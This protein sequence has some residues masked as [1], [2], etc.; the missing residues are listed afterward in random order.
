M[1]HIRARV[2]LAV[3]AGALVTWLMLG[4]PSG[5]AGERIA[6]ISATLSSTDLSML[7]PAAA[8]YACSLVARAARLNL[9]GP[10][11]MSAGRALQMTAI[12]AGLGHILPL[13]LSD[14]A[15]VGLLRGYAS[16]PAGRGT[17]MVILSKL[18]DVSSLGL[19]IS[20]AFLFGAGTRVTLAAVAALV[21]G[22]AGILLLPLLPGA[23]SRIHGGFSRNPRIRGFLSSLDE[24]AWIWR[25]DRGRFLRAGL[26]S[27]AAWA[28]KLLM[29]VCL[30]RAVGLLEPAF[31]QI[32]F[33]GGVTDLIMALPVHG[34]FS[35]GTAEA[36]WTAGFAVLGVSGE[37]ILTAGF[38]VH[39]LWMLMAFAGILV[40]VP[41]L[42]HDRRS[43]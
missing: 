16:V 18:M 40:A 33:A 7:L 14:I 12:H 17:G 9:L 26:M 4:G 13:R 34:L 22:T 6:A 35:L 38:G 2:V 43:E 32:F 5:R 11:G 8:L 15:L 20:S 25:R 37:E 10:G 27:V 39:I 24:A 28:S 19:V 1:R 36:G 21:A 31:W 42:G 3:A 23:A 29:F 30:A 41:L